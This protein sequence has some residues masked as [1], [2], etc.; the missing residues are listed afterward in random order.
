VVARA[1]QEYGAVN[2]D[3][4]GGNALYGEGCWAQPDRKWDGLLSDN[5]LMSIPL[6]H[7]RVLRMEGVIA[8]GMSHQRNVTG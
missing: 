6:K 2:T 3:T 5:G 8:K 4:G 1:L 7:Y